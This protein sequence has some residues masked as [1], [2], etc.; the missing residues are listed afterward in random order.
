MNWRRELLTTRDELDYCEGLC[1]ATEAAII[2]A[3]WRRP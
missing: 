1:E 3:R 2:S